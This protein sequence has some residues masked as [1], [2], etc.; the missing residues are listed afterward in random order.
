MAV[1]TVAKLASSVA[2]AVAPHVLKK[3][4]SQLNPTE[5]EKALKAGIVAAEKQEADLNPTQRLFFRAE[6]DFVGGFLKDFFSRDSV[7]EEL[8][9]PLENKGLPDVEYLVKEFARSRQGNNKIAL[10][11][12]EKIVLQDNRI[13]PWLKAFVDTYFEQTST[14][15][16][17]QVAKEDYLAQLA[18]Q[19]DD[20]KF[21][22]ISVAG[23]EVEKSAHLA[24]IFVMPDVVEEVQAISSYWESQELMSRQ[25]ELLA[26]QRERALFEKGTRQKF[27]ARE[28]VGRDRTQKVVLLGAPGS[29]KTTLLSYFAVILAA[30]NPDQGETTEA[31]GLDP[32]LDTLPILIRIRDLARYPDLSV[33]DYA[34]QFAEKSMAVKP[35][36][37][38]FSEH[39][40]EDGR[41]LILLDGLDEVAEEAK[42]YRVVNRIECFLGQFEENQ[43]IITSRPAGYK[44]DFF[45][46]EEFPHYELQS[47]DESKIEAFIDHWY[48]SRI[49]D[50]VEAERRKESLR[51]ALNDNDRI[52]LLA[53]NPLLLTIIALIHR[54]QAVL[55]RERYKLYNK[56]V[57]T[58]LTSWDANK[59]LSSH[60]TLQYLNLDDLQRLM[61]R[62]AY[63]IHTQGSTGDE[64]GGTLIDCEELLEQLSREIRMQ[65]SVQLFE[66]QAEAKRFIGLIQERTGL[67]NEQG[68]DCYAFVHK[69]FQEYLCA[70][71]I[72]Y[73]HQNED[74]EIILDHIQEHL[75]DPHWREVLLLLVAQQKPKKAAKAIRAILKRGSEYKQWLHRDL[76]FAGNCLGENPKGLK[77]TDG[78]LVQEILERLVALEVDERVG[79]KVRGQVFKILCSFNETAFEGQA[80]QLLKE[81]ESAISEWRLQQYQAALGEQDIVIATLIQRL[82]DKD[83]DVR[84]S[85]ASALG[86]LGNSSQLVIDA[87]FQCL[88][89]E[90]SD[91]RV[92]AAFAL[93]KLGNSSQLVIDA[94]FQCLTD[95]NWSVRGSAASALGKL[96]NSSQLVIDALFQCLADEDSDVRVRAAF[97]L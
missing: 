76:L 82:A 40:L 54:Y 53:S 58:L 16:R 72:E 42:R 67:L 78:A 20:V 86:K 11:G 49:S 50:S 7:R 73:Q 6:P 77:G 22:G 3:I 25:A 1:A 8:V 12:N 68:Q 71:E 85:A 33:I 27:S 29:G 9:K 13:K 37:T 18:K 19:F 48:D 97:A 36:P 88:A 45:R 4:Q 94:L 39:W 69:T 96:G 10:Q 35:L 66:A 38:G 57:E 75:H 28:F 23:Q 70:Q 79:N 34:K 52:K 74:F 87:L 91:V 65:K 62:I 89:D 80:L 64:E 2:G 95:E 63:W 41:A 43:A 47:F 92:R 61:E 21:A 90:D 30:K 59:E 14:Y 15:L 5:V 83:S 46:T 31:L 93:G 56:A 51:K 26:E 17:F 24:E 32:K 81:Q 55:P 44:R 60:N 84:G